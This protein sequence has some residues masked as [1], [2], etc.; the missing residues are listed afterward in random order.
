MPSLT[1]KAHCWYVFKFYIMQLS[2]VDFY[3]K[4][5][6]WL[7]N[8]WNFRDPWKAI[9]LEPD[10]FF[11]CFAYALDV[12]IFS[13][14]RLK[15]H[16]GFGLFLNVCGSKSSPKWPEFLVDARLSLANSFEMFILPAGFNLEPQ[17]EI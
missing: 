15:V 1:Q 5:Q 3:G 6:V 8:F 10:C 4:S 9:L 2:Q 11:N 12:D 17:T 14:H 16:A 7:I 13:S